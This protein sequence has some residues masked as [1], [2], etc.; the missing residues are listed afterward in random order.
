MVTFAGTAEFEAADMLAELSIET[1]RIILNKTAIHLFF[2]FIASS[3]YE[4]NF[5]RQ[6]VLMT[7]LYN[8][9][10]ILSLSML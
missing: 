10:W 7:V 4:I 6:G 9:T 3:P 8:R 2:F 5:D 1:N